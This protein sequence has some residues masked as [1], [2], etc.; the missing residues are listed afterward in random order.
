M[1]GR[2]EVEYKPL[3]QRWHWRYVAAN[4]RVMACGPQEGYASR[5]TCVKGI[6]TM[7]QHNYGTMAGDV[8]I[9]E[10]RESGKINKAREGRAV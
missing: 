7:V 3:V 9:C 5:R 1:N 6:R 4:K 2:F 10:L 8:V